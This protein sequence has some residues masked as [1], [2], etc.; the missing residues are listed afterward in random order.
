MKEFSKQVY[1]VN[2]RII[3]FLF[4]LF[5]K[6]KE[7]ILFIQDFPYTLD[8]IDQ[9]ISTRLYKK[10]Y[11]KNNNIGY[12][13]R[14][15]YFCKC[16]YIYADNYVVYLPYL[17]KSKVKT[18]VW[19][20][21]IVIKKIGFLDEKIKTQSQKTLN[22]YEKVYNSFDY[23]IV[24]SQHQKEIFQKSFKI[25]DEKKFLILGYTKFDIYLDLKMQKE[26]DQ[27]KQN[28][29]NLLEKLNI[30]YLPTFRENPEDNEQQLKIIQDLKN[31]FS[32]KYNIYYKFH[33]K[34]FKNI[35]DSQN[36]SIQERELEK[37]IMLS[38]IIITDYS[39]V[40]MD[41]LINNKTIIYYAYDLA[42]YEQERGLNLNLKQLPGYYAT[43]EEELKT[44]LHKE[45]LIKFS[46]NDLPENLIPLNFKNKREQI[47]MKIIKQT[48]KI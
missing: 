10:Y 28:N 23:Y 16:K 8:L 6:E 11:I 48:L 9:R 31:N 40:N 41:A 33:Q 43:T 44:I 39:S 4:S 27:M 18:Q 22:R 1:L 19:H 15:K 14:I 26:I 30:L 7:A 45:K 34:I 21:A 20:A 36:D 42:K 35:K 2:F 25:K 3:Y 38:D 47:T 46:I 13:Q 32:D 12:F 5:I 37:Y 29:F 24:A 17:K